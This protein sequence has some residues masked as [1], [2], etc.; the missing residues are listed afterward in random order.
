MNQLRKFTMARVALGRAGDALPWREVLDLRQAHAAAR[1]A[2]H[3]PFDIAGLRLESERNG[4]NPV[5]VHSAAHDRAEYL[6]RPDLGRLLRE[7][8]RHMLR[9]GPF[10]AV[11]IVADGLSA[12]AVHRHAVALL[13]RLLPKLHGEEWN[14]APL[15]LVE[16]GRVAIGDGIATQ[17]QARLSLVLLGERPGLTSP[18]SL[19]AYLTWA[20][21]AGKTDAERN[22]ISNIRPDG[23]GY[24]QA[25]GR[26]FG[27]MVESRRLKLSGVPLKEGTRIVGS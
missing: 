8:A 27:L 1:D 26:I 9:P 23:L 22:C 10:D 5:V 14:L 3:E 17:L 24:E 25:A 20:P 2:V 19:G 7:D 4:W 15:V 18:D 12:L 11:I 6:R 16:Q 21:A 13:E